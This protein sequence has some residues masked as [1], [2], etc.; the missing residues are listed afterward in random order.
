MKRVLTII[1][2]ADDP[3]GY[4]GEL[5]EEHGIAYDIIDASMQPIPDPTAYDAMVVFG[6]PQNANEDE[7][8]PYFLQ[9]KAALRTAVEQDMPV[10]GICLGGQLL[11]TV[12]GGTVKK[13]TI[14]EI[15]FSEVQCTDEGRHDPL[16]EGLAGRQLVYQWHEDTFDIPPGA[17]RLATS[18]KTENQAFR[19]GRNAY[20]IQYHIELT[21]TMLD[22]WLSE[23]S[24]KQEIINALGNSE[25]ERIMSD[26]PQYYA[27]YREH[28]RVIFENFLRIATLF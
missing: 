24:L 4:I 1:N 19:Y 15:G 10:L 8:Y 23:P 20:G 5:L 26:R 21:P 3:T 14:T 25:Y 6:G 13:H 11:A 16:Y 28:T 7:K 18:A 9:E 2:I 22:T 17:V 12:L 27:Q